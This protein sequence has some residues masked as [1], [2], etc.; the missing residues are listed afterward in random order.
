MRVAKTTNGWLDNISDLKKSYRGT[1]W[2]LRNYL[3]KI[4]KQTKDADGNKFEH[5]D[6]NIVKKAISDVNLAIGWM[7]T[8]KLPGSGRGIERRAAYQRNKGMDPLRM[9]AYYSNSSAGSPANL[10][11]DERNRLEWALCTLTENERDCYTMA[12]G[13]GFSFEYIAN[14][15]AIEKGTVQKYVERAQAKISL[16]VMQGNMFL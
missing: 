1:Y 7:H 15:L 2:M 11:D 12:H 14:M 3:K 5:G 10:T 16:E 13:Q 8:G 9:Q 4:E 6:I